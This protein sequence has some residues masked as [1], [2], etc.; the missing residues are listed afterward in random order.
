MHD[1]TTRQALLE[2]IRELRTELD[3]VVAS[4]G[5]DRATQPGSFEELSLKDVIARL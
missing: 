5:E 2:T 3:Q 4:A 1:L